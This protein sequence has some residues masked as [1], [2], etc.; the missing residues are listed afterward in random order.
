MFCQ[1]SITEEVITVKKRHIEALIHD[2]QKLRAL[3]QYTAKLEQELNISGRLI[4]KQD[5]LLSIKDRIITTQLSESSTWKV[6][7][8]NQEQLTKLEKRQKRRWKFTS[9]VLAGALVYVTVK[10][11][12]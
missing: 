6:R 2:V 4:A 11:I 3:E 8:T 5:S 12:E 10:A 9:V 1:P 7:F